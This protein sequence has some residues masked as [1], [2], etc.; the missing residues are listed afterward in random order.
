MVLFCCFPI[1]Y[2]I[3]EKISKTQLKSLKNYV[4]DVFMLFSASFPKIFFLKK[5]RKEEKKKKICLLF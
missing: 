3:F 2:F 4:L 5:R 1:F